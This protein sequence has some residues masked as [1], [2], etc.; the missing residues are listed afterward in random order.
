MT[1]LMSDLTCLNNALGFFYESS[2]DGLL[3]SVNKI[4]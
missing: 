3:E 2:L 1:F 4:L